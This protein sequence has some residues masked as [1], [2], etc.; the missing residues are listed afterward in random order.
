MATIA[1]TDLLPEVLAAAPACPVPT[2]VRTFRNAAKE[3]CEDSECYRMTIDNT[4]VVANQSDVEISVPR[5]TTLH[6]A[7]VLNL[8]G[9]ELKPYSV[10]L[11]GKDDMRWRQTPGTPLYWM[12]SQVSTNAIRLVPTPDK[13]YSTNGLLGEVSL[14][15]ARDATGM[16]DLFMDRYQTALVDGAISMLLSIPSAPW[17]A[18]DIASYHKQ[19]FEQAKDYAKRIANGDDMPK[20]RTTGY[21]GL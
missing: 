19:L 21:G 10:V 17:Y 13:T 11:L 20:L 15:P 3:L 14:K 12:R 9:E 16:S 18:P 1:F 5:G 2:I 6:R 8:N 7:I 4:V